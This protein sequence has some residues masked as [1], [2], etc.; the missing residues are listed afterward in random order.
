MYV[1]NARALA[2][3]PPFGWTRL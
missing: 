3:S 1:L 2:A